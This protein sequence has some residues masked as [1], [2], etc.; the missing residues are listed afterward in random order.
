MHELAITGEIT[1]IIAAEA[2]SHNAAK[3][4]SATLHLGAL[5]G[6]SPEVIGY[7]YDLIKKED[8]LIADSILSVILDPATLTCK[9]CGAVTQVN[10]F[11]LQCPACGCLTTSLEGGDSLLVTTI[12]VED[13]HEGNNDH[14]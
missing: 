5:T 3:V 7:Y 13:H 10:D 2:R 8:P 14:P 4:L 6:F 11:A 1:G 9:E 12:D